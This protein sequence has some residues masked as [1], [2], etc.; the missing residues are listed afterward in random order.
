MD[1][2]L[3]WVLC[4]CLVEVSATGRS[5]VQR[6]P[7]DCVVFHMCDQV[8]NNSLHLQW[9]GRKRLDERKRIYYTVKPDVAK[10]LTGELNWGAAWFRRFRRQNLD[11]NFEK[12]EPWCVLWWYELHRHRAAVCLALL[13][14]LMALIHMH[15]KHFCGYELW[16][17]KE[18]HVVCFMVMSCNREFTWTNLDNTSYWCLNPWHLENLVYTDVAVTWQLLRTAVGTQYVV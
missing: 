8:Q 14:N 1:V 16:L 15:G 13:V 12:A 2:C 6:S 18:T 7:A 3:V 11:L 4:V 5:L 9:L 10:L 17:W